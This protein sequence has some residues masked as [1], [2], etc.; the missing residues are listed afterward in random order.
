[1]PAISR[2]GVLA[3][4]VVVASLLLG[5]VAGTARA[6]LSLP[7][8]ST[9]AYPAGSFLATVQANPTAKYKV[10]VQVQSKRLE[11]AVSSWS[12]SYGSTH[13]FN[14]ING[15]SV[16]MPGWAIL[17]VNEHPA[18]FGR[19]TITPD[20]VLK[21]LSAPDTGSEMQW[22]TTIGAPPL[23][24]HDAVS[25]QL[26]DL[27][28][29]LDP[30]CVDVP[31]YTAAQ[32]PAI[33]IVDSGI[34]ASKTADFGSRVVASVNFSSL[35]PQGSTGD[36][37]GH[38]TMVAG[39]AAGASAD[40]PG[41]A[42]TAPL[43]DVRTADAQGES[44]TSDVISALDWIQA[45]KSTY[46]IK[47]VNMSMAGDVASSFR[48]DPL[49]AAVEKLWL[50]GVTVV[51]AA[52]NNGNSDGSPS[53]IG[54]PANDPFVITVG[55]VDQAG[56]TTPADDTRAP[57]SAYGHT[58]DGFQK[59]EIS[60]PGRYIVAPVPADSTLA[61]TAPDRVV[62]P[63]YMWM[64]GTSLA[65]PQV[66]GAA[67][68][69]LALHPSW[70]P[71]QVKGAL[72]VTATKTAEPGLGAGVGEL[73]TVA[74]AEGVANPPNP[75][76]N[77]EQFVSVDPQSGLNVMDGLAWAQYVQSVNGNWAPAD[78][79]STD[80]ATTDWATTDWATTD[81]ATTDWATTDWATTD[82][83][84]TDWATTD[85]A[86]TDWA[87]TDWATTDWATTDWATTDWATTDWA[88]TTWS[89]ASLLTP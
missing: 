53:Q 19:M 8:K 89:A 29:L 15:V 9:T 61:T 73:N 1:M 13:N 25:C 55:A 77:L 30:N 3:M 32:A 49:D 10:I 63:G 18:L 68:D 5:T 51:T 2:R 81:W 20:T 26:D 87:T 54:A 39:I 59:P 65:A 58:A 78:F 88:T 84:T 74:A 64:S 72:M 17:F 62:A 31:A 46:N 21:V 47:V 42:Q 41:V 69:I 27:G 16:D 24:T 12:R 38:G 37:L 33:A 71:D 52:G 66:A 7:W 57:W 75:N 83:A 56:T 44:L 80:W 22:P 4:A 35:S 43:V 86:T 34:D 28:A 23:W 79:S 67:A 85:W 36:Q 14:L 11:T 82:W 60:A 45:N 76:A 70:T 50:N 48:T 6:S 40:A